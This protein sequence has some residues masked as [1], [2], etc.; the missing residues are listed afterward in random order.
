M[1]KEYYMHMHGL[2]LQEYMSLSGHNEQSDRAT[3]RQANTQADVDTVDT[4]EVMLFTRP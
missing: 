1:R 2:G 3:V 4:M